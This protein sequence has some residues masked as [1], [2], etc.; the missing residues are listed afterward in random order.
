MPKKL[1][2]AGEVLRAADVNQYLT[3]SRNVI[4]N[5]AF[6]VN[7]RAFTSTTSDATYGFDRWQFFRNDGT[8]TYSAQTFTLGSAPVAGF[9][10]RNF[11]RVVS[12]GQ[13]ATSAYVQLLQKVE[14]VRT[15]AGQTVTVSFYA[16]AA[17]GAPKVAVELQQNFGTG[18]SSVVDIY[19][20]QVTLS[21]AW[22]RYSVTVAVPS[23]TGKTIGS[24]GN[25]AL[26]VN[27]WTSAGST[28]NARTGS[29]GIQNNTFDIWGVQVEEGSVATEFS[30]NTN[31]I[32]AELAACQRYFIR[33]QSTNTTAIAYGF[34]YGSTGAE[35]LMS[36]PVKMRA[37]PSATASNCTWSD[38]VTF[39]NALTGFSA[40]A[41]SDT[42][43]V[44]FDCNFSSGGA[45]FRPGQIRGN[46]AG[47][48]DLSAE[49]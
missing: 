10:A 13:S 49:L 2:A 16:R 27:L 48:I 4:I 21:T 11:A 26:W 29:M 7:Q 40:A 9:E 38:D 18:G 34:Q 19:A 42:Q 14:S 24:T 6:E 32:Q 20:G 28:F 41:G 30:R 25:D 17:S 47:N 31:S 37:V 23:I 22:A 46:G 1:F 3:T 43:A 12:S 35:G 36:L 8:V 33:L 39:A 45:Q 15:F 5:G 44:R